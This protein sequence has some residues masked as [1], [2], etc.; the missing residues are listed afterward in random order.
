MILNFE[1]CCSSSSFAG[2]S[3]FTEHWHQI[4]VNPHCQSLNYYYYKILLVCKW[5]IKLFRWTW[6]AL[7][8]FNLQFKASFTQQF[9]RVWVQFYLLLAWN[10]ECNL[11]LIY[12]FKKNQQGWTC[13]IAIFCFL[14]KVL[15]F[16][17][18][19]VKFIKQSL[20]T[21]PGCCISHK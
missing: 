8:R 5:P 12:L 4:F 11:F 6:K 17:C 18:A 19:P 1:F 2:L 9:T 16:F 10:S 3:I 20:F 7:V 13:A 14:F 15:W 21:A